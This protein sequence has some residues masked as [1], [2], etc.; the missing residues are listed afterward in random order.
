[1]KV[2]ETSQRPD[3]AEDDIDLDDAPEIELERALRAAAAAFTA[4]SRIPRPAEPPPEATG[5]IHFEY[6][7]GDVTLASVLGMGGRR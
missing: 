1:M 4:A 2:G 3:D 6:A 7:D 5:A